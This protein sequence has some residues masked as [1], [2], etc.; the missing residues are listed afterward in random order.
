MLPLPRLLKDSMQSGNAVASSN[1]R[2]QPPRQTLPPALLSL[3][4]RFTHVRGFPAKANKPDLIAKI[5]SSPA[6]IEV[7]NGTAAGESSRG[8]TPAKVSAPVA[9]PQAAAEKPVST[10]VAT[11]AAEDLV[12]YV[13]RVSLMF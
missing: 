11:S 3:G 12:G 10:N 1:S 4:P 7:F 13:F 2:N 8:G 9:K 6:A 5:V